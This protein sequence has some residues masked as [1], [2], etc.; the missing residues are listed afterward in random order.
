M[1]MDVVTCDH[2]INMKGGKSILYRKG[3][4]F[5]PGCYGWGGWWGGGGGGVGGG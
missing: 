1:P 3:P 5:C 4:L 2:Q